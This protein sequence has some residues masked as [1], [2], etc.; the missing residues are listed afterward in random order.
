MKLC[1]PFVCIEAPG[2][3]DDDDAGD[4]DDDDDNYN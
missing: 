3:D 2:E 4:D 1:G